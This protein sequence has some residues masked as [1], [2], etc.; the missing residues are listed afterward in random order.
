MEVKRVA[1]YKKGDYVKVKGLDELKAEF[2][3][4]IIVE[5]YWAS[6]FMDGFA[7]GTW[8]IQEVQVNMKG[9]PIYSLH[10]DAM[11]TW[12]FSEDTL[13]TLETSKI[14]VPECVEISYEDLM[15]I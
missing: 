10:D 14:S 8:E 9:N 5:C 11:G 12:L 4:Q 6:P 2:G 7:G 1:Y 15:R 3:D 13:D